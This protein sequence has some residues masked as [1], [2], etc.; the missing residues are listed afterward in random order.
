MMR[1][2]GILLFAW[3]LFA[4]SPL[5]FMGRTVTI[6][7]PGY[8]DK[9]HMFPNGPATICLEG[10]P[11]QCYTAPKDRGG[12]PHAIIV[13]VNPSISAIFFSAASGG[14]SGIAIHFALVRPGRRNELENLFPA[15]L[16]ISNQ[17]Q[18]AWWTD[19]SI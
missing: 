13:Q 2:F 12:D 16:E 6:I 3:T 15:D 14:V 19:S 11:R 1:R 10:S 17:G 18:H 7:S 5:K 4:Q 9:E 8:E